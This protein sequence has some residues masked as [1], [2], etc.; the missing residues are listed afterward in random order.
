MS[1]H[2][3]Y[4]ITVE[5]APLPLQ[6]IHNGV[7]LADS[8]K[9]VV[10][11]ETG[12][13]SFQYFPREDVTDGV[14]VPSTRR[15]F[16]PFKGTASYWHLE[17]ADGRIENGAFSYERPFDQVCEIAGHIAFLDDALDQPLTLDASK[18][19]ISGPLVDWLLR[20]AWLCQTPGDRTEQFGRAMIACGIPLWRIS[21]GI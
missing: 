10:M 2:K 13:P 6:A 20:D 16:C 1:I 21:V 9:A 12:L 3:A 8:A 15:T 18:M 11:H 7:V 14:L 5:P 4:R 17:L 19:E